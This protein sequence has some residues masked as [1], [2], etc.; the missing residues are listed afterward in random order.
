MFNL[1]AFIA[2]A[3]V[4]CLICRGAPV[5]TGAVSGLPLCRRC[6]A[7]IPWIRPAHIRCKACGRPEDCPDCPRRQSPQ[8]VCNRSAV[9]YNSDMKDW[10]GRYKYRGDERLLPIFAAMLHPVFDRLLAECRLRRKEIA[11]ISYVPLSAERLGERGFNQAER[12]ARALAA[13]FRLPAGP[14]LRRARHTGKQSFKTRSDR[15]SDLAGVFEPDPSAAG[16]I[17]GVP[18]PAIVLIDDVYTTGSTVHECARTI[19]SVSPAAR[20]YSLTWAR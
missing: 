8:I 12:F 16:R 19:R 15:I 13:A 3:A 4:P 7:K 11:L 5:G 10:L 17:A 9:R 14:L 20:I 18:N 1:R 6:G 2:P